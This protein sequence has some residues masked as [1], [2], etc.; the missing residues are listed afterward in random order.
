MLAAP[1][2][3]DNPVHMQ[4][5]DVTRVMVWHINR[6]TKYKKHNGVLPEK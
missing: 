5:K 6:R 2:R 1:H 4:G 3:S